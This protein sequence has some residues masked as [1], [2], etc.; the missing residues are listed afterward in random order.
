MAGE[1]ISRSE[2][3][4]L[5]IEVSMIAQMLMQP[6]LERR[7]GTVMEEAA[8]VCSAVVDIGKALAAALKTAV[9]G[10]GRW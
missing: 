1:V 8:P 4:Y 6:T 2:A 3:R 9:A 10:C 5:G 7:G